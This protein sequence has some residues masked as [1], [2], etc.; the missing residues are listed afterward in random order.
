MQGR[1]GHERQ[2][3]APG[4]TVTLCTSL[5]FLRTPSPHPP[6]EVA[7][8][9]EGL[10]LEA[11]RRD[12]VAGLGLQAEPA[13]SVGM[14]KSTPGLAGGALAAL[15]GVSTGLS[16]TNTD[17]H[18]HGGEA[19]VLSG[20]SQAGPLRPGSCCCGLMGRRRPAGGAPRPR[21]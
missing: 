15:Q 14:H 4:P 8:T 2:R 11:L 16:G 9:W 13:V 10:E 3:G 18:M 6:H 1:A 7:L 12:L 5:H 19:L 21:Q 17:S 20:W